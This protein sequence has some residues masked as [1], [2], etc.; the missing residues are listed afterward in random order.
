MTVNGTVLDGFEA[1]RD[2][3]GQAQADD[4]GGAQ[5]AVCHQGQLVVDLWTGQDVTG[6]RPYTGDSISILMSV[7]KGMTATCVHL[8][9]QRGLLDVD[10]PVA[11]Y[12]PEFAANGKQHV[13]VR[14]LL[15]HSAGLFGFPVE[16]RIGP[17]ELLDW[18]RC[19]TVLAAM[20]PLWEPGTAFAYHALTFGYLLGEVVHRIVGRTVGQF[21]AEEIAKPLSLDLWI[22]LPETEEHRVAD[23]FSSLPE[24]DP[25]QTRDQLQ[26]LGI[27]TANPVVVTMLASSSLGGEEAMRLLNS[28]DGHA[29]EV[30]SAN[31]IGT[32]RS[33]AKLYA[34]LIGEVDGVRLLQPGTVERVRMAQT[35]GMTAPEPL[36]A[37]PQQFPLRFA[38]GYEAPRTGSPLFGDSCFGHAGLGGRLAFA[39]PA[40]GAGVGYT[41]TNSRWN[42][43]EGPDARWLP[44]TAA[45]RDALQ[46]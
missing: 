2:A 40:T 32:A 16:A 20:A 4:E 7:S 30:P 1:V 31:G 34:A 18:D 6:G 21:F 5:L 11:R 8:L 35:D 9:G 43:A 10:V 14:H 27:D 33:L 24:A 19:I 29:A 41:C 36:A 17:R 42:Y 39:D 45:L 3:F 13:T 12:W 44:W 23:Q 26:A 37:I 15:T 38:L 25:Q 22:G 46:L 28:K